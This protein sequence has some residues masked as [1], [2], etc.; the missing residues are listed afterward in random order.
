MVGDVPIHD[1]YGAFNLY[2]LHIMKNF[3]L[4]SKILIVV[5]FFVIAN[6]TD[7]FIGNA[8]AG[9]MTILSIY[10]FGVVER[11]NKK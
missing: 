2:N 3:A 6:C 5:S 4:I 9:A 1:C 10:L 11:L 8:I 7:L